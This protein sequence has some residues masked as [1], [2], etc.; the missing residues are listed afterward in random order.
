[1]SRAD[2]VCLERKDRRQAMEVKLLHRLG[3]LH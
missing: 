2:G 3:R 1:M